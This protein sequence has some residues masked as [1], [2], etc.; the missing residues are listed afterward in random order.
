MTAMGLFSEFLGAAASAIKTIIG[1]AANVAITTFQVVRAEYGRLKE[2]YRDIDI[3]QRKNDRFDQLN[4]VNDEIIDL[5]CA[6]RRD[7]SLRPD[8]QERLDHLYQLRQKLRGNIEAAK[9]FEVAKDIAEHGDEYGEK[10]VDKQN[11]NEL[12]RLGGQVVMGKLCQICKKQGIERPMSIRWATDIREPAIAD[13]FWGCTGFFFKTANGNPSCKHTE[14]FSDRDMKLFGQLDR[15]G[16]EL[17]TKKLNNLVLISATSEHIKRK[18]ASAVNEV[19]E[20]YLCPV[21]NERR[22][23]A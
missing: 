3:D 4:E 13:L 21:H 14:N 16:M 10:T 7:G 15:P 22:V 8:D 17:P 12:T 6:V 20:N 19:T 18:L 23:F 5:E 11:P 1:V 9:E 2:K